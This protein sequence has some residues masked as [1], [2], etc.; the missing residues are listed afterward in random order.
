M[1]IEL[2]KDEATALLALLDVAVKA[3]G[4]NGAGAALQIATKVQ[5]AMTEQKDQPNG[6]HHIAG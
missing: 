1:T 6:Q 4:L 3:V 2:T 5:Q